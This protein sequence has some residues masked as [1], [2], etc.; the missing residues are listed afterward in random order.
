MNNFQKNKHLLWRTGFGP[1]IENYHTLKN[2]SQSD[3]LKSLVQDSGNFEPIKLDNS[4]AFY[5]YKPKNASAEMKKYFLKQNKKENA[6]IITKWS[7]LMINSESQ[8]REK[9]AFFW[10][11]HFATRIVQS[12]FNL[13]LLNTI[14]EHALGNFG[15]M[16]MAV[17]K[18]PAMLQ[19]LNNQTNKKDH[20]NE[21]FA[22]EVMEL[23]TMGRGNYTETDIKEAARAFTGWS[24]LPDASFF[25][26]P[27][28]HDYGKK[29]FLGKTGNFDG[30][31][32]LKIILEQKQTAKFITRKIY[33]FFVNENIDENIVSQLAENF[34]KNNY[35]IK[36]LMIAIFT[37]DWFF[38]E[39]NMGN[40]IKSPIELMTGIQ[41]MLPLEVENPK[42]MIIF[43]KLLGQMLLFPPNVAGW[44]IGKQWID[45]STLMLRLKLPQIWSGIISL[46]YA[47]KDDDDINMGLQKML[48]KQLQGNFKINWGKISK[49][50]K[51]E[52][53][54]E[55]LLQSHK[56]LPK[57]VI[58]EYEMKDEFKSRI[59]ALMSTPEYQL[60]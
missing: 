30:E 36:K 44:P 3:L 10:N 31:D 46:D 34:Y 35:D 18:S 47:P 4:S 33:K 37:S 51:N 11:G 59:I 15:E 9:M 2:I 20:P 54:E 24:F 43:Q 48:P 45:S 26:R 50:L 57:N 17:S 5:D 7:N 25:E 56:S 13:Q 16:L 21:N 60:C 1:N 32:I 40:R 29:T 42:T 53:L 58:D 27:K 14:R 28:L 8:L 49:N 12:R 39:K 19:F 6:E 41:R 38:D 23:F 22:R 52:N 55:A